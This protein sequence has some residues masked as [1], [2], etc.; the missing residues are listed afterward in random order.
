M[1]RALW[2]SASG[3]AAQQTNLDVVS[4]NIANVNTV[5]F[6]QSRANFEDLIYQNIK[7][8]GVVSAD[9][10]RVPSGIQVGLG[11]KVSDVSKIFSQGSLKHTERDL[12]VA[13]EGRGFFKIE[14]PNGGE[15]YTRAGNFQIDNEGYIVTSEGYKLM[16]NIQV[17]SPETLVSISIS[18]NGKV[19]AVRNEGGTQTVEE[20]GD[21][22]LYRFV[23]PAGLKAIGQNLFLATEASSEAV[24]GDPNTDGFGKLSQGFLESSN[25]N[26]VE[27]MVNL[28][29]AQRAYEMNSKGVTTSDEM[30]RTVAN[31]KS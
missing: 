18:P 13:I 9:G 5:G 25:V 22:K 16:P 19:N 28:I 17:N 29:V 31:L 27:E 30:L 8:P 11:V 26:I 10:N 23:N 20:L 24:E 3:M 21:I 14:L 12:D 6:K 15:A 1:I 7:D 4:H 2:T